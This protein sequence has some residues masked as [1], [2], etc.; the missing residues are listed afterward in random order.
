M[1]MAA[2]KARAKCL[3]EQALFDDRPAESPKPMSWLRIRIGLP[4]TDLQLSQTNCKFKGHFIRPAED[5]V[6]EESWP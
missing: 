5:S 2:Y 3:G 4:T 6:G 1:F